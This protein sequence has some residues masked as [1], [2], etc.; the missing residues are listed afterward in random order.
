MAT[1]IRAVN[2]VPL[3]QDLQLGHSSLE[4]SDHQILVVC[5]GHVSV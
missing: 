1:Y 3:A 4:A 5:R 2:E